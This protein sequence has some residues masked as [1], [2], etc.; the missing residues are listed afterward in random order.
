M[1]TFI[2][3]K[4][5]Q[6]L[7]GFILFFVIILTKGQD[8]N[9]EK[10]L[11]WKAI[12][13]AVLMI[14]LWLLEVIPLY[15]TALFPLFL[16]SPLGIL[17]PEDLAV[18]YGDSNIYL[19]LGGFVLA[20]ALEKHNVHLQIAKRI[21]NL[22]GN[23][24]SQLLFG[25]TLSTGFISLWT[26][27][28]ATALMMLPMGFAIVSAMPENE[29]KSKFSV[30]LILSIAYA[31]SIGGAGT[32]ISS[33][34]NLIMASLINVDPYNA[35]IDFIEW[36][37]FGIPISFTFLFLMF[38]V[39]NWIL[40]SERKDRLN[41]EELKLNNWT[42]T[43][44]RV[45]LIFSIVVFLWV[46]KD[47]ISKVFGFKYDDLSPAILGAVALFIVPQHGKKKP[48]L[49]W[50]AT[51]KIPWGVLILFGGGIAMAK[52]LHKNGAIDMIGKSFE[53]FQHLHILL[54]IFI[55]V[56]IAVFATE[57]ISNTALTNI[58]VP[59]VAFFAF[60]S[61][62]S[63]YQL[64]IAV[65]LAASWAFM[66]PIGTPPNAI[67]FASGKVKM[68]DML[69]YGFI[70]NIISIILISLFSWLFL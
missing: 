68:K 46:A 11:M 3:N 10:A 40:G 19:F 38:F 21:I 34:P 64:S 53:A 48:L 33:P 22:V 17:K 8:A 44:L 55:L 1:K 49:S 15:V 51:K 52:A 4:Y 41:L 23:S 26:S 37:K 13:L 61:N 18:S 56:T 27:N 45:L 58:L 25:F 42:K 14:F 47:L 29:K 66:L 67:V 28:T 2:L 39:F 24:K 59:V 36:A 54:I 7:V 5:V 30:L 57:L 63:V 31:A 16:A 32:I 69:R 50:N 43:Q 9:P 20:I 65:T 70:L 12:S 35:N 6:L 62:F 60:N